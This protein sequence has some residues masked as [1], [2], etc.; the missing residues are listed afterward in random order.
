MIS[1]IKNIGAIF[2]KGGW[3]YMFFCIMALTSFAHLHEY[4]VCLFCAI[5]L[6]RI[7]SKDMDRTA[8]MLLLFGVIN[9]MI[10]IGTGGLSG[11]GLF[12]ANMLGPFLFYIYGKQ[13]ITIFES[14]KDLLIMLLIVFVAFLGMTY[15]SV[16]LDLNNVGIV[17]ENRALGEDEDE[18]VKAT[19]LGLITSIGYCGL[20]TFLSINKPFKSSLAIGYLLLTIL[21]LLTGVHLIN[22]SGLLVFVFCIVITLFYL[23]RS[24]KQK[25]FT[26]VF[27]V[28]IIGLLYYVY[29]NTI[30][31]DVLNAYDNRN[32]GDVSTAGGRS[33]LWRQGLQ[34]L[35]QNPFGFSNKMYYCHNLWI[36]VGRDTG[37]FPFVLIVVAFIMGHAPIFKLVKIKGSPWIC[38]LLGLNICFLVSSFM[39][40]VTHANPYYFYLYC[41]F[42]GL[43][44]ATLQ[45]ANYIEWDL[46]GKI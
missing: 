23:S 26:F 33:L 42:F 7:R 28:G 19:I 8:V 29:K 46:S 18:W 13:L 11:M 39:E 9:G 45:H 36:D 38:T 14:E 27:L 5:V 6:S 30:I 35:I 2:K 22:R 17:N 24:N 31:I 44:H 1:I 3:L 41:F 4:L 21:S 15:Y 16:L 32:I 25:H 43:Q 20:P 37:I 12:L 34:Y 10:L 40:P